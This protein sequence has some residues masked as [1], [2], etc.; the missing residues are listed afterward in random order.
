[1][2]LMTLLE[3]ETNNNR[4]LTPVVGKVTQEELAQM[5]PPTPPVA[6]LVDACKEAKDYMFRFQQSEISQLTNYTNMRQSRCTACLKIDR[7]WN[8]DTVFQCMINDYKALK[9][10]DITSWFKASFGSGGKRTRPQE[11]NCPGC[12]RESTTEQMDF[13]S[14]FPEILVLNIGRYIGMEVA[15]DKATDVTPFHPEM[16]ITDC[17]VVLPE[18]EKSDRADKPPFNYKL[19]AIVRHQ[20]T[21]TGGH[22]TA[23]TRHLDIKPRPGST[24]P[25]AGNWNYYDDDRVRS[26]LETEVFSNVNYKEATILFYQRSPKTPKP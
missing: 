7:S 20:G 2:W 17:Q 24:A 3:D 12:G 23:Y 16:D 13:I 15:G 5:P 4:G 19:Y 8:I 21:R 18:E 11:F 25:S 9:A 10:A 26:A 1:M 14:H 6:R 22:Y